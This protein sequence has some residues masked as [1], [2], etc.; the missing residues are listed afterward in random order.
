MHDTGMWR[1]FRTVGLI[2]LLPPV[3]L[4]GLTSSLCGSLEPFWVVASLFAIYLVVGNVAIA[5]AGWP[6][7]EQR[8]SHVLFSL[9]AYP[10]FVGASW[11]AL[12]IGK[13]CA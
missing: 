2:F 6:R 8:G 13:T 10:L 1:T 12:S 9:A 7:F 11:W 5:T 3:I 4:A